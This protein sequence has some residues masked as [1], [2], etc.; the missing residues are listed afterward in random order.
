MSYGVVGGG[1]QLGVLD[2]DY[3]LGVL[4]QTTFA[5]LR[6]IPFLEVL[7]LEH[8]PL[9]I[10]QGLDFIIAAFQTFP[11]TLFGRFLIDLG[12]L[13]CFTYLRI[14]AVR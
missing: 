9:L 11:V 2:R 12:F 1:V 5:D 13:G 3:G 6:A 8:V 14:R 10:S 4:I 7:A